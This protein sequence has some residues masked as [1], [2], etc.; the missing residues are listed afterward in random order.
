MRITSVSKLLTMLTL[1]GLTQPALAQLSSL[2][3]D[4]LRLVYLRPTMSFLT[5]HTARCF[6]NSMGFQRRLF[7]YEPSEKVSVLLL[8]YV[9]TSFWGI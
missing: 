7:G 6:E 1:A 5:P 8:D 4:D 2:E 3:T 9:L